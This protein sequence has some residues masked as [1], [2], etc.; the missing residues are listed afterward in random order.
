MK[1][2]IALVLVAAMLTG[3]TGSFLLTRKVYEFHRGMD[4]KWMDELAFLVVAFLPVYSIAMLG[5]AIVFNTIEFWTDTNPV[6]A[7]A[8]GDIKVVEKDKFKAIL[9][10]NADGSVDVAS[11]EAGKPHKAFTLERSDDCVIMKD[12]HGKIICTSTKDADG[13]I[14][15]KTAGGK[16]VKYISPEEVQAKKKE[17]AAI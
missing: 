9:E 11:Y 4:D 13:G 17:Y 7:R 3:C 5:D 1:R 12:V 10:Y 8:E 14:S 16:L 2:M 15:I 6:E